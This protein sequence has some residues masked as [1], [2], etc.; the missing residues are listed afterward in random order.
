VEQQLQAEPRMN[1]AE[2]TY[3][4]QSR[5]ANADPGEKR[6]LDEA[7]LDEIAVSIKA[8]LDERKFGQPP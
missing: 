7:L 8:F 1:L 4:W 5:W 3:C 2:L 6:I